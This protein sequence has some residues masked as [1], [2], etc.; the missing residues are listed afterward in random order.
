MCSLVY[1]LTLIIKQRIE[2][3]IIY[4]YGDRRRTKQ[5][6]FTIYNETYPYTQSACVTHFKTFEE[7]GNIVDQPRS[8]RPKLATTEK[9][10]LNES[11]H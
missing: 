9:I 6:V 7:T 1:C 2:I 3:L 4:R 10:A 5:E 11:F 8:G